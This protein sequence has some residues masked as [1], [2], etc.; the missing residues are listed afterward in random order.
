MKHKITQSYVIF[1]NS[2]CFQVLQF[3]NFDKKKSY[4]FHQMM[5]ATDISK[6]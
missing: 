5:K 2:N 1:A 4:K 6:L 3:K